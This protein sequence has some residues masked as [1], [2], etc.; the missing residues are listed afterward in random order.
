MYDF[1]SLVDEIVRQ[2]PDITKEALLN[3]IKQKKLTIGSG[4][5]TDQGALFV[6]ANELGISLQHIRRSELTL[7]D[8]QIGLRN[9][10]VKT[11]VLGV[12]PIKTYTRKDGSIGRYLRF[13]VFDG[14]KVM[15]AIAWDK[16]LDS[17]SQEL[18]MGQV[19]RLIGCNIK[20]A[21]D[22]NPE[23]SISVGG[24]IEVL[25]ETNVEPSMKIYEGNALIEGQR[26]IGLK[27]Q[28]ITDAKSTSFIRA[29]KEHT[30]IQ[31]RA[32]L[33]SN[34][35]CRVVI[36]DPVEQLS[37]Q[38][39]S[40]VQLINVKV[41]KGLNGE[42]EIHGDTAT[43]LN[44]V[45]REPM[46]VRVIKVVKS[47]EMFALVSDRAGKI[48][49]ILFSSANEQRLRDNEVVNIKPESETPK[50]FVCKSESSVRPAF[51]SFPTR[52]ALSVKLAEA[53]KKDSRSMLEV[54]AL[55]HP[56]KRDVRTKNGS[57]VPLTELL[58]G[59]DSQEGKVSAWREASEKLEDIDP[60]ERLLLIGAYPVNTKIG[61][62]VL[63]VD[64]YC[65]VEKIH[66]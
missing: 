24:K 51:V 38:K 55:S 59:D 25:A 22:G 12:Y 23:I 21:L 56:M 6:I 36:W 30:V 8:L 37:I 54:I 64:R 34:Q 42:L 28:A 33:N 10:T 44:T 9:V 63:Q 14:D 43:G 31:F 49:P 15:N 3:M 5:L 4:Y 41:K 45:E 65:V 20:Q 17:V 66:Y 39:G 19:V 50:Y 58:V 62:R 52:E 48:I 13:V 35:E 53:M 2:R 61:E 16:C 47:N 46:S 26:I 18:E 29:G 11:R 27:C 32:K 1:E 57:L 60:G 40:T 7:K